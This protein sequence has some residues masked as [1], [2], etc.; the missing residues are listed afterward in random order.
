MIHSVE[1]TWEY[2]TYGTVEVFEKIHLTPSTPGGGGTAF[3][4]GCE[5]EGVAPRSNAVKVHYVCS[6][7]L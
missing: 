3:T 5:G 6:S 1:V 4:T 2:L 7:M